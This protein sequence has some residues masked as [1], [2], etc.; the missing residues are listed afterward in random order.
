MKKVSRLRL[1]TA[2]K[3]QRAMLAVWLQ[4]WEI[5]KKLRQEQGGGGEASVRMDPPAIPAG[6]ARHSA[7]FD[8]ELAA[9]EVRLLAPVL[10]ETEARPVYVAVLPGSEQ[11]FPVVPFSRFSDPATPLELRSGRNALPLRVLCV[12]NSRV[13][14]HETLCQSWMVD[15]LAAEEIAEWSAALSVMQSTGRLP[16]D[17]EARCGPPLIDPDDPRHDYL[18]EEEALMDAVTKF[19]GASALL[20]PEPDRGELPKAAEPTEDY[21]ADAD[22][23]AP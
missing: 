10:R 13:L 2:S 6:A 23:H 8:T 11:H 22:E 18:Q 14:K 16:P 1:Q 12:W 3:R 20:Y 19:R 4:A 5:D 21:G 15:H 9:G 17:L 7:P